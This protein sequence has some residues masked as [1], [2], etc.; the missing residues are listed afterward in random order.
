MFRSKYLPFEYTQCIWYS[1]RTNIACSMLNI[2][3][4]RQNTNNSKCFKPLTNMIYR[5]MFT[6]AIT[7][8]RDVT[9]CNF[10][11]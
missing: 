1:T 11:D 7:V 10:I 2:L 9:S 3:H 5:N 6:Y 8:L 4:M